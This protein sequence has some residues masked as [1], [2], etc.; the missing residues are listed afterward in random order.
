[1]EQTT[2]SLQKLNTQAVAT[3]ETCSLVGLA[4]ATGHIFFEVVNDDRA[5]FYEYALSGQQLQQSGGNL[6]PSDANLPHDLITPSPP[7][8]MTWLNHTGLRWRGMHETDRVTEWA[9][10]LTIMEKMQILPH[11][12]RPLSPMQVLG[13]AESYVLSE[14]AVGDGETYLVCRRL[15]L[16]YALPTVQRDE[17]GDYDYDT[18]LCHVAHWVRGDA[19]PSWEHVFTDF[20]RAQIQ[21]PLDCLIH[22]GQL[23]MAD[24]GTA[25]TTEAAMCYLHIWQLS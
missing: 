22:E 4:P 7:K 24:S 21:A 17:N 1:M 19:E 11:L 20:D 5:N 3:G 25:S 15:R 18:L 2:H 13:V 12:G 9:Q 10:P 23:Y 6:L 16:A 8:A 14:A